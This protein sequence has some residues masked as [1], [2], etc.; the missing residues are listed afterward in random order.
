MITSCLVCVYRCKRIKF[1]SIGIQF[2]IFI[3]SLSNIAIKS[4]IK[5]TTLKGS[6]FVPLMD[7]YNTA[8]VEWLE[9]ACS[10]HYKDS[11]KGV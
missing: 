4:G 1:A 8:T 11:V 5:S 9:Q 7:P 10:M 3:I 2:F 6:D